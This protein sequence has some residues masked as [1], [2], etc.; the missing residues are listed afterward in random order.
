MQFPSVAVQGLDIEFVV[1]ADGRKLGTLLIS[2]GN[3]EWLPRGWRRHDA[4][5]ATWAE[6]DDWMRGEDEAEAPAHQGLEAWPTMTCPSCESA[7][8]LP[9]LWGEPAEDPG[10]SVIVGGCVPDSPPT[11][12]ACPNCGWRGWRC[13]VV[14]APVASLDELLQVEDVD[15]LDALNDL[16]DDESE[17]GVAVHESDAEQGDGLEL[18]ADVRG[19]CLEYP[20]GRA[21]FWAEVAFLQD[22]S[23]L[24]YEERS[25]ADL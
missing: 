24:A 19:I 22:V 12:H 2:R 15:S 21:D 1:R 25:K 11:T 4:L 7:S 18:R 14:D 3:I 13:H 16:V 6:F 20:F 17:G 5:P 8:L 23:M 9:I 10:P